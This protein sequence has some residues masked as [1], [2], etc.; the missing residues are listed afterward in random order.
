MKERKKDALCLCR[1]VDAAAV[2]KM[3]PG[4]IIVNTSRGGLIDNAALIHGLQTG[5]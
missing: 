3:K 2:E 4:V 1:M 5:A